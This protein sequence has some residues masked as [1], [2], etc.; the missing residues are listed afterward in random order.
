VIAEVMPVARRSFPPEVETQVLIVCRRRCCLCVFLDGD[1]SEKEG[2]IA[3]VDRDPSNASPD[4][5]AFLCTKHHAR[6]DSRSRQTKGHT[7]LELRRYVDMLPEYLASSTAWADT[8]RVHTKG[9]G[10]SLDVYDRRLPTYRA[11]MAFI[12]SMTNGGRGDLQQIMRFPAETDEALFLFGDDIAEYLVSLYRK[13]VRL[14]VVSEIIHAPERR[15]RDLVDEEMH[16]L[17]WFTQQYEETRKRFAPY[18]Y[19]G[20]SAG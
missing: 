6:Y 13:A 4:N 19:L 16:L 2:Q 10:V 8:G 14:H 5:A 12:R 3:H 17:L 11:V 15:T 1:P 20:R 18:L 7:P 9:R